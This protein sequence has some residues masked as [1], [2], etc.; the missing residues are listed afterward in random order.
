MDQNNLTL[1]SGDNWEGIY[2]NGL[3]I[4]E[5]HEIGRKYLVDY[6]KTFQT[7]DVEFIW[8]VDGGDAWLENEGCYP[9]RYLDIP[10]QYIE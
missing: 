9:A 4:Y 8:L 6:M 3:L 7:F 1:I 10:M 5:G 2:H